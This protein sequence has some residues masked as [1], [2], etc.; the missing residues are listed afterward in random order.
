MTHL[1]VYTRST[2][3]LTLAR[4]RQG[5]LDVDES[6]VEALGRVLSVATHGVV[7]AV[8]KGLKTLVLR[9]GD[10]LCYYFGG[11]ALL[12]S[13]LT[14]ALETTNRMINRCQE[15]ETAGVLTSC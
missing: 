13:I 10:E 9:Q 2:I 14:L 7:T 11:N 12:L 4:I 15:Y 3:E 8:G 5:E 1:K 6:V